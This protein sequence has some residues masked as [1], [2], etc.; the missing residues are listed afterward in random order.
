VEEDGIATE[1]Q[2]EE[3]LAEKNSF[4]DDEFNS[5]KSLDAYRL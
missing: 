2:M 5:R 1:D 3:W 4:E